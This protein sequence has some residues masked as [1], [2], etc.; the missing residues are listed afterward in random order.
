MFFHSGWNDC[1]SPE[2]TTWTGTW[3]GV[4]ECQILGWYTDKNSIWGETEDLNKY[5]M[6]V[7]TGQLVWDKEN[8]IARLP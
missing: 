2:N 7:A 3:P 8:E 5:T 4:L 1:E 6:A